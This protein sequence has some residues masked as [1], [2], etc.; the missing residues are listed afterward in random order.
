MQH[1]IKK[2]VFELI[3]D[4]RLNA[5]HIQ[6]QVSR[7]FWNEVIPVMQQVFDSKS[8]GEEDVTTID[9]IEIDL[10][11]IPAG[12]IDTEKWVAGLKEKMEKL[13]DGLDISGSRVHKMVSIPGGISVLK[14]WI[15]YMQRGYLPWNTIKLNDDWYRQVLE[16][17]AVDFESVAELRKIILREDQSVRR[18]VSQHDEKFLENLIGIMTSE[19]HG[20]LVEAIHEMILLSRFA[21]NQ[22]GKPALWSDKSLRQRYWSRVLKYAAV[23]DHIRAD[24]LIELFVSAVIFEI[25][26]LSRIPDRILSRLSVTR[27]FAE[28]FSGELRETGQEESK[29]Q[30]KNRKRDSPEEDKDK[31]AVTKDGTETDEQ[32][33]SVTDPENKKPGES[34]SGNLEE[35]ELFPPKRMTSPPDEDGIEVSNAGLVLLHPFLKTGFG[36]LNLLENGQFKNLRA[37]ETAIYFLHYLGTGSKKAEDHE[38]VVPKIIC[39]FPLKEVPDADIELTD[40]ACQE[41]DDL[42]DSAIGQWNILKDSSR[43]AFRE[44]FLQRR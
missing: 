32:L 26:L 22:S 17:L 5:Y 36:R 19:N 28:R 13:L 43:A 35:Q 44:G 29:N 9:R 2:Q 16:V 23:Q 30:L 8:V 34:V 33:L 4:K 25:P 21:C 1:I 41:A 42:L 15:F 27:A 40:D 12:E 18:I 10:G 24:R 31:N 38:L 14:Q 3:I 11:F 20:N 39:D 6:E 37:Q 7:R